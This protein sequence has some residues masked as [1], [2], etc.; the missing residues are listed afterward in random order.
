MNAR[1][2]PDRHTG[3]FN[4]RTLR[5]VADPGERLGR[6]LS[7]MAFEY[8]FDTSGGKKPPALAT[9]WKRW[10]IQS[11]FIGGLPRLVP[12]LLQFALFYDG[13]ANI[14]TAWADSLKY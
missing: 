12:Q 4:E 14:P 7:M 5:T 8:L 13:A 2:S 11:S 9:S 3:S 1:V 10:K 6:Q